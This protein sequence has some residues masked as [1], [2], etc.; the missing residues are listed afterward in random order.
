MVLVI[1]MSS[2]VTATFY[3]SLIENMSDILSL[4]L[5]MLETLIFSQTPLEK[6]NMYKWSLLFLINLMHKWSL[7]FLI[8]Q[9]EKINMYKWS[10]LFLINLM[11]KWSL[12]FL[13]HMLE[14]LIF[15]QTTS[16]T[17]TT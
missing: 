2:D 17:G 4:I 16:S 12:L 8:N 3:Q 15:S 13:I 7:L 14:T 9:R 6:I 5:Y 10:L 11:H 1:D